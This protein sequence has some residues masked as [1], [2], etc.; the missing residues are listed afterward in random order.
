VVASVDPDL[1]VESETL[2]QML[3]LTETFV[4]ASLAASVAST[5]GL[6]GLLLAAIGIYGTVSYMVTLRT[7]E[8][9]IRMALGAQKRD[10]VGLILRESTRPVVAGLL[11][12]VVLAGGVAYLLRHI[13]YGIHTIDGISF[14]G[15]SVLFLGIAL[16]AALVPSRRAVRIEPVTALR[17]E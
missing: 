10:V 12:G 9:G 17:C 7:R 8:V 1:M 15:V 13:L 11:V 3:R 14:G 5:T 4:V 6:L 16:L 2:E